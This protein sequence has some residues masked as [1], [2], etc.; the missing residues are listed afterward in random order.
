MR[1]LIALLALALGAPAIAGELDVTWTHPTQYTD[2]SA[3]PANTLTATDVAYGLCNAAKTGFAGTPTIVSVPYPTATKTVTG[4]GNGT[5]CVQARSVA[6]T[7]L[8]DWTGFAWKDIVLVPKPPTGLVVTA[9]TAYTVVKQR[10]RFVMLPVGTVPADTA[11][12][13]TQS[14]NGYFVVPRAAVAWSGSVRPDVVV[15]QCG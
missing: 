2:G 6:G 9:R 15:A 10:D 5:W 11:C 7:S 13:S 3:I 1:A 4:L 8:S 12:D 14:V